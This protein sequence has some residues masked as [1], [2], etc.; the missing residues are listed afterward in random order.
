MSSAATLK[1]AT[2]QVVSGVLF[3]IIWII[4]HIV[5]GMMTFFANVM[6]AAGHKP[7]GSRA[8]T[9]TGIL[10]FGMIIGQIIAGLAGFPGGAAFCWPGRR[11]R[12]LMLFA[13]LF[14]TG[15]L[16]QVGALVNFFD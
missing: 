2:I 3:S 1:A 16:I 15:A 14:V 5:W 12:L 10:I 8:N 7:E 9:E 13:G 11:K 4:A 6:S